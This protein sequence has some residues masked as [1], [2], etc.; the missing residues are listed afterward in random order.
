MVAPDVSLPQFFLAML[1][2]ICTGVPAGAGI[3]MEIIDETTVIGIEM[4][5]AIETADVLVNLH[6]HGGGGGMTGTNLIGDTGEAATGMSL[7]VNG[8]TVP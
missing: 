5:T 1:F 7:I 6:Q 8:A 3:V 4:W 2:S